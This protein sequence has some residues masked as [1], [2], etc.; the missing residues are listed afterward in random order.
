VIYALGVVGC[1]T[2]GVVVGRATTWAADAGIVGLLTLAAPFIF[3]IGVRV[4][5]GGIRVVNMLT[6][7]RFRW[8]DI[9]RFELAPAGVYP[10][11]GH[12]ILKSGQ[13]I[14]IIAITVPRFLT[15]RLKPG[16]ER[17]IDELNALLGASRES[18]E[19]R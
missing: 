17:P 19:L 12:V 7:K 9:D 13:D 16:A 11:A 14:A 6:S 8:N 1:V 4:D 3:R 5:D 2:D 10:Y 15:E 18:A